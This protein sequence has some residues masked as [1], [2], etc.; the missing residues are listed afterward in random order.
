MLLERLT[1]PVVLFPGLEL[2]WRRPPWQPGGSWKPGHLVRPRACSTSSRRPAG[3]PT[4]PAAEGHDYRIEL[5]LAVN[6]AFG[7]R[8]PRAEAEAVARRVLET[9]A[10]RAAA[11]S[12]ARQQAKA[13]AGR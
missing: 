8:R 1:D 12:E 10:A 3:P 9:E 4:Q 13:A 2:L 7:H 6:L 11:V 5:P